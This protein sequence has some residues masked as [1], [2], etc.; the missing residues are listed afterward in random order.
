MVYPWEFT[1]SV[2]S[3]VLFEVQG[4]ELLFHCMQKSGC[5][6]HS[7]PRPIPLQLYVSLRPA[8]LPAPREERP[9]YRGHFC[10]QSFRGFP[11]HAR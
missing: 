8:T 1:G 7:S 6:G 4:L 3:E 9:L 5:R 2:P 11:S 10:L